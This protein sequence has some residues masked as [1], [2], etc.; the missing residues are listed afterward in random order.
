MAFDFES[1]SNNI[2]IR[3]SPLP[4]LSKSMKQIEVERSPTG[5]KIFNQSL[6]NA[7]PSLIFPQK[8]YIN[9]DY[10]ISR[11]TGI[12]FKD[13]PTNMNSIFYV[14]FGLFSFLLYPLFLAAYYSFI[15]VVLFI[16]RNKPLISISIY[17]LCL[18]LVLNTE[19]GVT[20]YFVVLRSVLLFLFLS[21]IIKTTSKV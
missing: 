1:T 15:S 10:L 8:K 20:S 7:I 17:I 14:D 9:S 6:E 13:Y 11:Y 21:I 3:E 19:G 12:P 4:L 16:T 2:E 5:G 18:S